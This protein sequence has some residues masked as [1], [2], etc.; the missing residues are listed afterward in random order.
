MNK[1]LLLRL[2]NWDGK[3]SAPLIQIYKDHQG[4][5]L[6]FDDLV[7]ICLEVPEL[8]V[9][10]TWIIKHHVDQKKQV[11]NSLINKLLKAGKNYQGWETRI[12]MLQIL[13]KVKMEEGTV[14]YVEEWV[15]KAM[16]DDNKFVRAW[17]YQGMYEV[18]KHIPE[19][20]EELLLLCEDAL[21]ME[22][23][24]IKARVRKVLKQLRK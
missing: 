6:F 11:D 2:Q 24:S 8:Q 3:H 4:Q 9:P 5:T 16:K 17:S 12:H 10:A 22:S 13:P 1:D 20:K 14:P 23:A 15:R 18:T 7:D 19:M 21:E